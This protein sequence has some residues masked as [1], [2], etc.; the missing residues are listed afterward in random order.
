MDEQMR[1]FGHGMVMSKLNYACSAYGISYLRSDEKCQQVD[2]NKRLQKSQNDLL[3]VVTKNGYKKNGKNAKIEDMLAE[4]KYLSVTQLVAMQQI[5]SGWNVVHND[6]EPLKSIILGQVNT[7][8]ELRSVT[9]NHIR[10]DAES[11]SSFPVQLK[12]LWNHNKLDPEFRTTASK[13][14]AKNIAKK[15]VLEN[16]PAMPIQQSIFRS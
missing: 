11:F 8:K 5:M 16:I 2:T 9:N 10:P 1:I 3:R 15:F 7:N 6:I 4:T 13:N 14:S 12:R